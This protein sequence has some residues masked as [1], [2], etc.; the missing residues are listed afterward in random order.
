MPFSLTVLLAIVAAVA[1]CFT[2]WRIWIKKRPIPHGL[3]DRK[4]QVLSPMRLSAWLL[5]GLILVAAI[6]Q[7]QLLR[8]FTS[9]HKDLALLVAPANNPGLKVDE[10]KNMLRDLQTD[11][12]SKLDRAQKSPF[13]DPP[14]VSA[15]IAPSRPLA[16]IE[17]PGNPNPPPSPRV[18]KDKPA[19]AAF[20]RAARAS[21]LAS[22]KSSDPDAPRPPKA[23]AEVKE[24]EAPRPMASW[25]MPLNLVGLVR[26]DTLIV[27]QQ[28]S[29]TSPVVE[30]LT[31]GQ[32]VKVTEKRIID[33]QMWYGVI[34][35]SGRS[36]WVDFRYIRLK[37]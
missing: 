23:K 33:K 36:G 11:V 24:K 6:A 30:K 21:S 27:R 26:A 9:I 13:R 16:G 22:T 19:E 37:T 2:I 35:P 15:P 3:V 29:V 25:S 8:L 1:A 28:P 20:A 4:A 10:V 7:V 14:R 34:T 18:M 17:C 12:A 31:S 32:E 5:I